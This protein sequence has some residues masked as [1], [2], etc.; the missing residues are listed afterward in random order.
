MF[1]LLA[2]MALAEE[3]K[4]EGTKAAE[5]AAKPEARA[6]AE[7]GGSMTFGNTETMAL[8]GLG[9]VSYK[10]RRNQIGG[11]FGV[12]WGQ[13]RI[14]GDGDGLLSADERKEEMVQTAMREY[15]T[16]RYDRFFGKR[17]SLYL[18]AGA[19]TDEFAGYEYRI[20]GQLGWS[21]VFLDKENTN[22]KG[23][24]GV[25]IARENFVD[26]VD[27]NEQTV[28]AARVQLAFRHKFNERVGFEDTLEVYEGVLDFEDFRLNNTASLTAGLGA[29]TSLKLS[30]QLAFDNVPV[31]GF[32]PLDHTT[33]ASIVVNLL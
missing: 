1:I 3:S 2:T 14:D 17:D 33:M 13:S 26:G 23:E 25:D 22:F 29:R 21:H 32:Q 6:T 16:L 20:N 24:L 5:A 18:L 19:F 9:N 11:T 15:A 31:P 12:N 28:V 4:F 30:H 10:W 8:T 27:P 7:L